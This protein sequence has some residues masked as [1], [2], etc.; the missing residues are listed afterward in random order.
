M[1]EKTISIKNEYEDLSDPEIIDDLKKAEEDFKKGNYVSLEEVK[2]NL[3]I[4]TSKIVLR[5]KSKS[6]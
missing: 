4:G 3:G 1:T 6:I 2:K 5:D